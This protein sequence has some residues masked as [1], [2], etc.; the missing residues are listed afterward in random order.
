MGDAKLF[1]ID[2]NGAIELQGVSFALERSLQRLIEDN[3]ETLLGVRFLATE[4][5][6]GKQHA[7]RIDT[8]GL[9]ENWCPVIIE[10]KRAQHE[11]VVTQGLFYLDW[12]LDH[13]AEF[14]RLTFE[15]LGRE[16]ADKIDWTAPRLI[17]IAGSFNRYDEH[18]V[19]QMNRN[20]ELVSYQR[21]G[22]DLL[23]LDLVNAVS[24]PPL[25][26]D[27][28]VSP[29]K[30]QQTYKTISATLEELDGDLKDLYNL[31]RDHLLA[32]GDD[33]QEKTVKFYVAFRRIKNFA[34]LD[35]RA[36]R[37]VVLCYLKV[38]PST[39]DLEEGFSRDVSDIGHF[40]TGDLELTLSSP[41]DL[42]R[43]IPLITRS[44]ED[45]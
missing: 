19:M 27:E 3:L 45:S 17:C 31:I 44:Y 15:K 36:Q 7:G 37:G 28:I 13:K 32:L 40:G 1:R 23:L 6:T 34:C 43:A 35:V 33:V 5:G 14:W 25:P 11:N 29:K 9:D 2:K 41:A 39:V 12:L 18:A 16:A 38:D 24:G 4:Y 26:V 10:Y 22:Q 30:T 8:L 21:F 20:I 42:Q